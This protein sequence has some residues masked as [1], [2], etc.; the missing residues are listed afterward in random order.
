MW[1]TEMVRLIRHLI[2]DLDAEPTYSDDRLQE[3]ILVAAQLVNMD[4]DFD[5]T[6]TIDLDNL[7]LSPDPTD[8][9]AGTRDDAFINLVILKAAC[10]IDNAEARTAAAQS[11]TIRDGS[12]MI[13]LGGSGGIAQSK[14]A[15]MKEGWCKHYAAAMDEFVRSGTNTPGAII[16]G[17]YKVE[18]YYSSYP[19]DGRYR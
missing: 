7:I 4:V 17:P 9:T 10:L 8:R 16:L 15:I 3:L 1:Q 19:L 11:I 12:S 6:Y 18:G 13:G 2:D 14:L 5:T